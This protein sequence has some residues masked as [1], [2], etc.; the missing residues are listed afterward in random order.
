M[1]VTLEVVLEGN[2]VLPV[3][4]DVETLAN[5]QKLG[6]ALA[7]LPAGANKLMPGAKDRKVEKLRFAKE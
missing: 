1:K 3:S 2:M 4:A 7:A 6:T 5:L